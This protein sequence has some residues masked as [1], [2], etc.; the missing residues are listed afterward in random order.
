MKEEVKERADAGEKLP[1]SLK[2]FLV[3]EKFQRIVK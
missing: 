2:K 3:E 1:N